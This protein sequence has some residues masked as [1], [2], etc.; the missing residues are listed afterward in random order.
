M[1]RLWLEDEGTT[2]LEDRKKKNHRF[3]IV[4][5]QTQVCCLAS[6][7]V[8]QETY[9]YVLAHLGNGCTLDLFNISYGMEVLQTGPQSKMLLNDLLKE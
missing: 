2:G 6:Q 5:D 7:R 8:D 4:L 3:K 9:S 1:C